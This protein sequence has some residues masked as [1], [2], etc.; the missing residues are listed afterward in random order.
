VTAFSEYETR[1]FELRR[2]VREQLSPNT[3]QEDSSYA[4]PFGDSLLRTSQERQSYAEP[5][6][7]SLLR[8]SQERQSYAEPFGDSFLRILA[9]VKATPNRSVTAS[10]RS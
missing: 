2:T 10:S 5:F 9:N 7:D 4:E 3:R 8:T 1:I 6:G